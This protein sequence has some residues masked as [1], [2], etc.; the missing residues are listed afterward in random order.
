MRVIPYDPSLRA[1]WDEF[2]RTSRN[3]TFHVQRD[4]IEY[5]R[6]RFQDHSILVLDDDGRI[7][8][9]LPLHVEGQKAFS[10]K[11]LTYAGFIL[12]N[13][14]RLE[15]NLLAFRRVL[16]YMASLGLKSFYYK[17]IPQHYHRIPADDDLVFLFL[18]DAELSVRHVN[19]VIH[20]FHRQPF[21]ERRRRA[22]KRAEKEIL[23]IT[24][25]VHIDRYWQI[26]TSLLARYE[27]RPVHSLQEITLLRRAFPLNIRLF[28]AMKENDMLAG[29]LVFES[30]EVA[31]FQYIASTEEGKKTG[32]LDLLTA[33]L[34]EDIYRD[35]AH[36]DFGTS[37]LSGGTRL[38]LGISNQKEGFGARTTV[39]DHY[40]LDLE[41]IDWTKFDQYL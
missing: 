3:G 6:D 15:E 19:P 5:H 2:V 17:C 22:I 20:R 32:A 1:R 10:H 11:G 39:Q 35:K 16:E 24:E 38:S 31:K 9:L 30:E 40:E 26:L 23:E 27:S 14:S 12:H 33:K 41:H 4:F 13:E 7:F 29:I 28:C 21:Q 25:S 34:I 36:I 18:M 37:T 8:A